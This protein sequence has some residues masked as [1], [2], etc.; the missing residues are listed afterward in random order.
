MHC[1]DG[2]PGHKV[3]RNKDGTIRH[4]WAA[5][6]DLVKAGY[7]PK[8]VRLHYNFDDATERKLAAA[9]CRN[10]QAEMLAWAA[11]A[12]SSER[13]FDG[14]VAA[15][16]RRY[17]HDPASQY[18][19]IKWNT[20]RT[21]DQVLGVIEKAFGK[22][23]LVGL[24]IG[25]FRR[26]YEEAAKP[27]VAGGTPRVR[28]AHGIISMYR[29]IFAYGISAEIP[30]C[31]RLATILDA[32]RFKQ[33]GRRRVKLEL[34]HVQAFVAEALMRNRVSLALGTALQ[35]ETTLRQRDVI[36]EWEPIAPG[37]ERS[38]IALRGRSWVHGL[39]WADI[40]PE[41][42]IVKETTKT[43]AVVAH[44]L[45][46][47]PLVYST[48]ALVPAHQRVGP[49]IID[50]QAGRPY[51]A[52]AYTREWRAVARAAGVP[53]HVW[54][55][56]ARAGGISEGDDAGADLDMLRSAAGHTQASTTARYVRGTIGK[57]RKVAELRQAHREA[58]RKHDVN[59]E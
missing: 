55:M 10:L 14:T 48:L 49:L 12:R 2:M 6:H 51:A 15:L 43:G 24:H 3:R 13:A 42:T 19:G 26:W 45:K 18:Q 4:G 44:D 31:A 30:E 38:G 20:R 28:K 23:V 34:A 16:V 11:G 1:D 36:G 39:T 35:F 50:E 21:Y 29:R 59:D 58:A 33:P 25:D 17:Q 32:S 47:C 46:L 56:D 22:R 53:D 9:A 27:K 52:H 57:S 7:R 54:N 8:W 40:S 41:M 37:A 5:R